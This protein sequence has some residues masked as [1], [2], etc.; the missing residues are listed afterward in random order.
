MNLVSISLKRPIA[1]MC[2]I[3]CWLLFG[4]KTY[5][6]LGLDFLPN[7]EIPFVTVTVRYPGASPTELEADVAR[8]IE[9]AV[10]SIDGL[11]A[12]STTCLENFAQVLLEFR[13]NRDVDV[14][15]MDVREKI[16]TVINDLPAGAENPQ[17]SK[18]DPNASQIVLL[19]LTGEVPLNDLYDFAD[20]RL[21]AA[22]SSLEGVADV[23]ITGGSKREVHVVPDRDK[24]AARGLTPL[25]VVNLLRTNN[26]K[27]PGGTLNDQ[28]QEFSVTFDAEAVS[29]AAL[30]EI[31]IGMQKG[32]PVLLRD[33]A[34]IRIDAEKVKTR[35]YDGAARAI[36]IKIT[37]K[38][39]A[40]AV[41]TVGNVRGA[42]ERMRRELPG[43]MAL[44]WFLDEA[45]FIQSSVNDAFSSIF[46]GVLLTALLLYL[47]LQ[48]WRTA[49][50]AFLT[51]PASVIITFV[52]MNIA[53]YT[54]NTSTLL[55]IGTGVG[56]LVA[57]TIVVLE[58]IMKRLDEGDTPAEAARL[59]A[60]GVV[61][62]VFASAT[63]NVVVFV[64]MALMTSMV[65]QFFVPF[66]VTTAIATVVSLFI[67]FTLAPILAAKIMR[68]RV[69]K[70]R[71]K[72]SP[73]QWVLDGWQKGYEGMEALYDQTLAVAAKYA[74]LTVALGAVLFVG[75]MR[76]A[77]AGL[78]M[79]F[80]PENDRG[81]LTVQL[82]FPTDTNLAETER[83]TLE[84]REKIAS[85]A[86]VNGTAVTIGKIQGMLGKAS[87]GS[88][89]AEITVRLPPM[90]TRR[91]RP[92]AA[93]REDLRALLRQEINVL[94]AVLVPSAVGGAS[95]QMEM[96]IYGPD[97]GVLENYGREA[98]GVLR[99]G[100][101]AMEVEDTVRVG[102]PEI[103]VYPNRPVLHELGIPA[104]AVG[105]SVR[106][107]LEG[108]EAG[109]Y[110]VGDRVF[111]IRVK[112]AERAG[113]D[114]IGD[115]AFPARDGRIY[116]L[117]ALAEPVRGA[118]A[119]QIIRDAKSRIVKVLAN[120][121]PGVPLGTT[122]ARARADVGS[123][124]L[125]GYRLSFVGLVEKMSDV[126]ADFKMVIT[127]ALLLTYLSLAAL[128]ESWTQPLM[129]FATVPTAAMG[130]VLAL[131][132]GG[133]S[134]NIMVLLAAVMMIGV[135]V[136]N[137]IL[138]LDE[139]NV[140]VREAGV[141]VVPAVLAAARSKFRPIVMTSLAAVV[142]MVP[143]AASRGLGYETR[144]PVGLAAIGGFLVSAALSVYLVPVLTILFYGKGKRA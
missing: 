95:K 25:D 89:L 40:N 88:H 35:A 100:G 18:F 105:I 1:M 101:Y 67:S 52:G 55:A 14:A 59:G 128:L 77:G 129:I 48:D 22:F 34:D 53:G 114:Q 126:V 104:Q 131:A 118:A 6:N 15:A 44:T 50:I 60:G 36:V 86:S 21:R 9:D 98:V 111:D 47:F 24:L 7:I 85:L 107:A 92:M 2:F 116:S 142:G 109:S 117:N 125:P 91:D 3:I 20:D 64:P 65:G 136:N 26:L 124:L 10:A 99:R 134:M 83:R 113:A 143:L 46:L 90:P 81:Q 87:E 137:A 78:G 112:L 115:L 123:R 29:L 8:R 63:T 56:I 120:P 38:G 74:W 121:A 135:V 32:M 132:L 41:K 27:V 5:Q 106:A 58:N 139:T 66:A 93:V 11:K 119:V 23:Q 51:M 72:Y 42:F 108:V 49:L 140:Q 31:Q 103:R 28:S 97:L 57:N 68:S 33:V 138:I 62:A 122:V 102:K 30:G 133:S 71:W 96:N 110:T 4:V 16:D 70:K 76:I 73:L 127:L 79:D 13:M 54:F 39:E 82:E 19:T 141:E 84:L 17:I 144:A 37:K 45:D 80:F 61:L 43:G 94:A 12:V 130:L 69:A 75:V